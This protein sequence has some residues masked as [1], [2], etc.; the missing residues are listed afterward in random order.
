[1]LTGRNAGVR[2]VG[3]TWGF[4]TREELESCSPWR[5]A[6]DAE[7]LASILTG[8]DAGQTGNDI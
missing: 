8:A 7:D 4:R 2:T 3:V 6:T 1:M 5:I